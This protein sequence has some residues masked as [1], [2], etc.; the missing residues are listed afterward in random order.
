MAKKKAAAKKPRT[1]AK[2]KRQPLKKKAAVKETTHKA[3]QRLSRRKRSDLKRYDQTLSSTLYN[4]LSIMAK[5]A[6]MDL[7]LFVETCLRT[8]SAVKRHLKDNDI[9][10]PDRPQRGNPASQKK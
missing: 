4:E 7:R 2:T 1:T 3:E 5:A 10:L 9:E 8:C 6:N